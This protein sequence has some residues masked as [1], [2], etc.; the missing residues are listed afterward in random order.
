VKSAKV[1]GMAMA[2]NLDALK[3]QYSVL[4]EVLQLPTPIVAENPA[5]P[6]AASETNRQ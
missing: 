4:A 1:N 2:S 6:K 5:T 3:L